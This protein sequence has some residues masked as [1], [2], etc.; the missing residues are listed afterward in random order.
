MTIK[1]V[2]IVGSGQMGS[3]IA[4]VAS[5]TNHEVILQDLSSAAHERS[6]SFISKNM[7]KSVEKGKLTVE[8]KNR[9]LKSIRC[10]VEL[11][12]LRSCD[13]IIEAA[14]EKWDVKEGIFRDLDRICKPEAILASN[15]SS[16]SINQIAGATRRPERVIGMHFMNPVPIMVLVEIIRGSKTSDHTFNNVINLSKTFGKI[17]LGCNDSP[18]FVSN[19]ILLPMINEAIYTLAEGVASIESIDG[20]MKLGMN[21][22]MGPL[23][24]A[25]FI[26]LDTSLYI[27]NV[28]HDG[29]KQDKYRPC[30]LLEAYV[31]DGF[32]GKKTGKGFYDYS[33]GEPRP[34][35]LLGRS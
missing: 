29:L 12:N 33:N 10:E 17:P 24:L 23:A 4:H 9:A 34:H 14:T 7:Q 31:Q 22:P 28:L 2:G 3:G 6:L 11:D 20:I 26:G 19:R 15:T 25:D 32:L 8:E 1:T 5:L 21:H 30:P 35:Y 18:G 16:I 13:I 27:L